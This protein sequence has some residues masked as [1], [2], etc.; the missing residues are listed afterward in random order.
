MSPQKK[1][2]NA[3]RGVSFPIIK[4]Y[5]HRLEYL[6]IFQRPSWHAAINLR[7]QQSW[8]KPHHTTRWQERGAEGNKVNMWAC[9]FAAN[10][11]KY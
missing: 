3:S 7:L 2:G 10:Q 8:A 1:Y 6:L 4:D 9:K 11:Q 5:E